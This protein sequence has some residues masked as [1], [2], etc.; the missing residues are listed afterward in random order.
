MKFLLKGKE[1]NAPSKGSKKDRILKLKSKCVIKQEDDDCDGDEVDVRITIN[2]NE[3]CKFESSPKSS[4]EPKQDQYCSNSKCQSSKP[5]PC[6][7]P[8]QKSCCPPPPPCRKVTQCSCN[9][10]TSSTKASCGDSNEKKKCKKDECNQA[11]PCKKADCQ[12]PQCRSPECTPV[13]P[14]HS[15]TC[16]KP[17]CC[18]SGNNSAAYFMVD[19]MANYQSCIL[20]P[21]PPICMPNMPNM[22]KCWSNPIP[23]PCGHSSCRNSMI[24]FP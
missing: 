19:P 1:G 17:Q 4:C 10:C 9:D 23:C 12:K 6:E 2:G 16:D 8:K 20:P 7:E 22:T 13:N 5:P 21:Q 3:A 15:K 14:C 24:I 11:N 18:A